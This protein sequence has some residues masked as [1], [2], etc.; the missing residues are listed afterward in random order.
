M[1]TSV[2][3]LNFHEG[4]EAHLPKTK[5]FATSNE[6]SFTYNIILLFLKKISNLDIDSKERLLFDSCC[7]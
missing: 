6:L 3:G 5:S 7:L 1:T 2:K 4:G